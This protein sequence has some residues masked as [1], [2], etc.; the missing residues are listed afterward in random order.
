[1]SILLTAD[2]IGTEAELAGFTLQAEGAGSTGACRDG[3][4]GILG[5]ELDSRYRPC[6]LAGQVAQADLLIRR[7][8][9]APA[10]EA[11]AAVPVLDL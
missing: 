4:D 10:L 2:P 1:M 7:Q 5:Q 3:W 11:G 8:I 6:S 9:G